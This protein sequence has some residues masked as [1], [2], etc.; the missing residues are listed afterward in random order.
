V[1]YQYPF[2]VT[3]LSHVPGLVQVLRIEANDCKREYDLQKSKD[4]ID[5]V[6][7]AEA[8]AC[9][10]SETHDIRGYRFA[11]SFVF[12]GVAQENVAPRNLP[13]WLTSERQCHKCR[14][15]LRSYKDFA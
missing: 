11:L 10:I 5:N 2:A 4:K 3:V 9:S 12:E 8:R 14:Q 13:L 7:Q 1:I 15:V 6:L